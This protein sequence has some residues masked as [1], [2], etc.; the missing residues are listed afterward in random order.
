VT[1]TRDFPFSAGALNSAS[2]PPFC[3]HAD[4]LILPPCLPSTHTY[5]GLPPFHTHIPWPLSSGFSDAL[6]AGVLSL[7][8]FSLCRLA[9]SELMGGRRC[10]FRVL[11]DGYTVYAKC[12]DRLELMPS[13]PRSN[14]LCSVHH[15]VQLGSCIGN[16]L[17]SLCTLC[18]MLL[19]VLNVVDCAQCCSLCSGVSVPMLI[20]IASAS[21]PC[22][23]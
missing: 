13:R 18:S 21:C 16:G 17:C 5:P 15:F 9:R 11:C 22:S 7:P 1:L 14:G 23:D 2:L 20:V 19:T 8:V 6:S 10:C 12:A 4:S 3:S